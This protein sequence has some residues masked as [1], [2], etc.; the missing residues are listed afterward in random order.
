MAPED[1]SASAILPTVSKIQEPVE[2]IKPLYDFKTISASDL[3]SQTFSNFKLSSN[4]FKLAIGDR[5]ANSE[6]KIFLDGFN[7]K[8]SLFSENL[9]LNTENVVKS[10]SLNYQFA[11][12][13]SDE[14]SDKGEKIP[15]FAGFAALN[16]GFSQKIKTLVGNAQTV[17]SLLVGSNRAS[18]DLAGINERREKLPEILDPQIK[19]V[20]DNGPTF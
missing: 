19:V 7:T 14:V 13:S 2:S 15:D 20:I 16:F 4:A 17:R 6:Q 8:N 9:V 5:V 10:R 1:F 12:E 11:L 18:F 3:K